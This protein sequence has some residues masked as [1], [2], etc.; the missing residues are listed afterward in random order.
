[1]CSPPGRV[2]RPLAA[3]TGATL[4]ASQRTM[5]ETARAGSGAPGAHASPGLPHIGGS[6]GMGLPLTTAHGLYERGPSPAPYRLARKVGEMAAER[7]DGGVDV[8]TAPYGKQVAVLAHYVVRRG[9][10]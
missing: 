6:T 4:P 7:L 1:M 10:P 2:R 5:R 9:V 8:P 3:V